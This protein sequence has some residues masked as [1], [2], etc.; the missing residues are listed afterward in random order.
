LK[1]ESNG[2]KIGDGWLDLV[3]LSAFLKNKQVYLFNQK[4]KK[5]ARLAQIKDFCLLS[6]KETLQY[7]SRH[8]VQEILQKIK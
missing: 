1:D 5:S 6:G 7:V 4:R 2:V 8:E 3:E